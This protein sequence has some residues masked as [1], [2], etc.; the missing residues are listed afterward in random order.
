MCVCLQVEPICFDFDSAVR[1]EENRAL[2]RRYNKF[3]MD[4]VSQL[5]FASTEPPTDDVIR[6]LLNCVTRDNR[7]AVFSVV[8]VDDVLDSTPVLRSFLLKHLLRIESG[9]SRAVKEYLEG[10][11]STVKLEHDTTGSSL[12]I[13][14][15]LMDVLKVSLSFTSHCSACQYPNS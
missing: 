11:L 12:E 13:L 8:N 3:F 6:W 5:V 2:R 9:S 10:L 7:P 4:F 14:L 15:L 1:L